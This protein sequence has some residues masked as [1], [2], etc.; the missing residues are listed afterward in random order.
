MSVILEMKNITKIYG[1]LKANDDVS[2]TLNKGEILAV[3]GENGAGK[4]TLMKILYGLERATEGKIY[5]NDKEISIKSPHDAMAHNIG[6][7][8]QHFML[9][10]TCSVAENVVYGYEPRKYKFFFD[11]KKAIEVTQS[12][13]E[14][15]SIKID[16]KVNVGDYP[17]GIQQR[18][19]ILKVLYQNSEIIIFDEPSAV[20][21]PKEVGD[22]LATIKNLSGMGKSIILITHK[23]KEVMAVADR[24]M[25]MR[26]GKYI[27]E[28]KT[29]EVSTE[30]L[31][32][33]MVGK[34]LISQE[35]PKIK[36]GEDILRVR[37]LVLKDKN[38]GR[39]IL[40]NLNLWVKQG[41]IVGIAGVSGNGQSE[42][43]KVLTGLEKADSGELVI[44]GK[45]VMGKSAR[46]IRDSGMA[47]IPE[48][49]YLSGCASEANLMETAVMAHHRKKDFSKKGLIK[50]RESKV[51]T[52]RLLREYD[53]R[54][55]GISQKA[56]EL[57][58]GNIQKLIV[59]REIEEHT[60]CIIA[61]EPT[62]GIDI[63][64]MKYVHD[65]LIKRRNAMGG[66]LLISSELSEIMSLSDRIYVIYEGQIVAEF[67]RAEA[68][69]EK[70]GIYMMGGELNGDK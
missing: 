39:N 34:N 36:A 46:E 26:G 57:S 19:E 51:F 28:V 9:F 52:E 45:N 25:V 21:T 16:P 5:L 40:S 24:V 20:L 18:V 30:E 4:S 54:N 55:S 48:D 12:L 60:A 23:L 17:V 43:I 66:V 3:I 6:M 49:R 15:Y 13:S 2:L 68:S 31:S 41:E 38:G 42:L 56:G 11:R 67:S 33:L 37:D 64:A 65:R 10:D 29:S 22:L 69:E 7:V 70:I 35:I 14:K 32:Y 53:V 8:Q 62:R 58:G 59:A 50:Y 61:A 1:N 27:K 47:C 44:N 63:G